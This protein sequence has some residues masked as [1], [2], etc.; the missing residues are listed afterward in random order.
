MISV[1]SIISKIRTRL[2]DDNTEQYRFSDMML[3]DALNN[4]YLDLNY[5]FKL[6]VKKYVKEITSEDNIIRT[7]KMFL[8]FEKAYLN[9][10]NLTIKPYDEKTNTLQISSFSDFQSLIV[11]PKARANGKLEIY[12]NE[13]LNLELESLLNSGDF[14]ENALIFS[15]L[16]SL[17]QIESNELNL[18]R[19]EFYERLY[20]K[21]CDRLRG[22]IS[23]T[24]E[25]RSFI[26]TFSY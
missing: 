24:R 18:Q 16:I 26:T 19:V 25:A 1:K 13:A 10:V 6:N 2:R 17:F 4:A 8:S 3:L 15:S 23:S 9:G 21:E 20:K 12:V 11:L 14:L 7:K 5:Q 22:L